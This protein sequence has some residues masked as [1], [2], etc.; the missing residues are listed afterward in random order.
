M[1]FHPYT[2]C[3]NGPLERVSTAKA[4]RTP[5]PVH[6]SIARAGTSVQR[7]LPITTNSESVFDLT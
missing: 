4:T 1:K 6:G 5:I 7:N 3:E 2:D